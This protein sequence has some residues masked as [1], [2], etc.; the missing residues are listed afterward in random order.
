MRP[1][2]ENKCP[3]RE[4]HAMRHG[5]HPIT[6]R[7]NVIRDR[8]NAIARHLHHLGGH[9]PS[10]AGRIDTAH[11]PGGCAAGGGSSDAGGGANGT[12]CFTSVNLYDELKSGLRKLTSI[13]SLTPSI[14]R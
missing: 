5:F 3:A 2:I 6:R 10:I 1:A 8:L 4:I 11:E 13:G 14:S 7:M 9:E 12:P